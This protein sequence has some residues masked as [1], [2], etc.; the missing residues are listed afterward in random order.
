MGGTVS[1]ESRLGEGSTFRVALP[2]TLGGT[3]TDG[4]PA[5]AT[6]GEPDRAKEEAAC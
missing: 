5:R 1:V 3:P 6:D 2:M 4:E